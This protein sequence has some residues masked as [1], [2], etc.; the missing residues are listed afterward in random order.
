ML[1]IKIK[2]PSG[3]TMETTRKQT[4]LGGSQRHGH[5]LSS[6]PILPTHSGPIPERYKQTRQPTPPRTTAPHTEEAQHWPLTRR[7]AAQHWLTQPVT[8]T[9][10]LV[11]AGLSFPA[12]HTGGVCGQLC[13]YSTLDAS[14]RSNAHQ[15]MLVK[16]SE[17]PKGNKVLPLFLQAC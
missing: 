13:V 5:V 15:G 1:G 14:V 11:P 4:S 7:Q 2:S 10:H 6:L 12:P 17:L 9:N 16:Y 8:T 3:F